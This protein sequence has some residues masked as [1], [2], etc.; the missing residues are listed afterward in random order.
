MLIVSISV[1]EDGHGQK[2]NAKLLRLL[3]G[4]TAVCVSHDCY[5]HI[6]SPLVGVFWCE[7]SKYEISKP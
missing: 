7:I 1:D 4:K 3:R 6:Y 5:A 2:I